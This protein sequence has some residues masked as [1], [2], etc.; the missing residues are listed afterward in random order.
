M[1]GQNSSKPNNYYL[2]KRDLEGIK[3][4]ERKTRNNE[5]MHLAG[6]I[7]PGIGLVM[8]GSDFKMNKILWIV[9][10]INIH[11]FLLQGYNRIR[12]YRIIELKTP[13]NKT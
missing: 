7:I 13:Y 9:L 8:N 10:I 3:A 6:M 2:W 1:T 4:Y 12:L 11:P 5:M